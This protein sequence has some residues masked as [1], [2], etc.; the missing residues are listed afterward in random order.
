MIVWGSMIKV[1]KNRLK[2]YKTINKTFNQYFSEK[3]VAF[4]LN[5]LVWKIKDI[6]I[7]IPYS[8]IKIIRKLA[9]QKI[10]P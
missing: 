9:F 7:K 2:F 4:L 10:D 5:A 3:K 6:F 1:Q 8:A